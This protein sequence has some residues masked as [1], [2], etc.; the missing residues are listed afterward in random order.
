[1]QPILEKVP[2]EDYGKIS[3]SLKCSPIIVRA[4]SIQE[5]LEQPN[6]IRF[7]KHKWKKYRLNSRETKKF[8]NTRNP[9]AFDKRWIN[10]EQMNA[11]CCDDG[12]LVEIA[13]YAA[14]KSH[15]FGWCQIMGF[16][17]RNCGFENPQK[18]FEAMLTIEGQRQCFVSFVKNSQTL[19]KAFQVADIDTLSHHYNGPAFRRNKYNIKIAYNIKKLGG[20]HAEIA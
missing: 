11:Q 18:W 5:S 15:S 3:D 1:M 4:L 19:L 6:A 16:N 10:F 12:E 17:H 2:I 20:I 9:N 14:I 8:D 13:R 7:E